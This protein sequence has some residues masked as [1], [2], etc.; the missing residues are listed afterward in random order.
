MRELALKFI[1]DI[2]R[3]TSSI[4]IGAPNDCTLLERMENYINIGEP[5]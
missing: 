3:K 1:S 4:G 2:K 5:W